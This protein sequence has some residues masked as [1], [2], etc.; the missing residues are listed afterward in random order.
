MCVMHNGAV[1]F[2]RAARGNRVW[3]NGA[4]CF[5]G[6]EEGGHERRGTN[7]GE[8]ESSF[9]MDSQRDRSKLICLRGK[10]RE[11]KQ[12]GAFESSSC[13]IF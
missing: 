9:T 4:L 13:V 5:P 12:T 11:S 1:R 6:R 8:G 3:H 2:F 10:G 7:L